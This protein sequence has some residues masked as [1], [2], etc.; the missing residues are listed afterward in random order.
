MGYD[1][2]ILVFSDSHGMTM[3]MIDCIEEEQPD[4]LFHLGDMVYDTVDLCSVFPEIPLVNVCGNNDWRSEAPEEEIVTVG[5]IRFFLAHGH[6][7]A[8]R[9]TTD[10]MAAAARERGCQVALFGHTHES[11]VEHQNGVIVANPGSISMPRCE[12][13]SYLRI[14]LLNGQA[15]KLEIVHVEP[16]SRQSIF[17]RYRKQR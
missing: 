12:Q 8:V 4:M 1:M 10:H 11:L 14:L 16:P 9:R 13:P 15:P 2:K 7:H 17:D 6:R 5:E 3:R